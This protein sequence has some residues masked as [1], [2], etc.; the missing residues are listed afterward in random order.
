MCNRFIN[1]SAFYPTYMGLLGTA[2]LSILLKDSYLHISLGQ[3]IIILRANL[4]I[5]L[6]IWLQLDPLTCLI[7]FCIQL[8][9]YLT[10][11]WHINMENHSISGHFITCMLIKFWK[12]FL[13][14]RLLGTARLFILGSF[15]HL[16]VYLGTTIIPHNR[17]NSQ[18]FWDNLAFKD[19]LISTSTTIFFKTKNIK[20]DAIF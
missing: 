12:N 11:Q 3:E 16:H 15:S 10:F 1:F 6:D 13:P 9:H 14:A 17:V 7:H 8:L 5:S 4:S 20:F 2:R 18:Y 19:S